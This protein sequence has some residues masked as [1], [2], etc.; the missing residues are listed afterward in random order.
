M[1]KKLFKNKYR[2]DSCRLKGWNYSRDG[3]YFITICTQN[4]THFFG[5]VENYKMYLSDIGEIVK[6]EWLKTIQIRQN[7][8]L[9]EWIIMPNHIHVIVIID[10]GDN[11]VNGNNPTNGDKRVRRD[12]APQRLYGGECHD[13]GKHQI[14]RECHRVECDRMSKISPKPGSLSEIIRSFK[15]VCTKKIRKNISGE[16]GWQER[17]YDHIIRDDESLYNIQQYIIAN[18]ERWWQDRNNNQGLYM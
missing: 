10:N 3:H 14:G 1:V 11:H 15:S 17:F 5:Q 8:K 18:P 16:F 7:I 2:I 13:G 6:N 12:V 4:R 9:G